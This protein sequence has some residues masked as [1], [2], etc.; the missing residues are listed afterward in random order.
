MIGVARAAPATKSFSVSGPIDA[1]IRGAWG[2]AF[3]GA[4]AIDRESAM[5]IAAVQRGRDQL[6]SI[7]TLPLV[8][9]RGLDVVPNGFLEQPDPDVPRVVMLAQT[10]EDLLCD[11]I[12]WWLKTSVDYRGFPLTARRVVNVTAQAPA[13]QGTPAPLPSGTDPRG[14][15]LWVDGV[16]VPAAALIRFDSP[17]RPLLTT[18]SR[19]VRRAILLDALAAMY[20]ENPRPLE[21]FTDTDN[22]TVIPYD[23]DQVEAF[24]ANY[25]MSRRRGGPAWVPKQVMRN[26]VSAPSPAELQLVELQRQASLELALFMGLDPE[27][28][29]VNTTSR[30]YFNAQ[31]R[32]TDKINHT[33]GPIMSAITDRLS[34]GDITPRGQ[35]VRFDLTEYLKPDPA[36]LVTY[37]RGLYDMNA[38]SSAEVRTAAGWSGSPPPAAAANTA[39]ALSASAN[40]R[41]AGNTNPVINGTIV[42]PAIT[43]P[44]RLAL[45]GQTFSAAPRGM[46]FSARDFGARGTAKTDVEKRTI[47][48]LAVPYG[49]RAEK[50]GIGFIFEPGSL[51]YDAD[52]VHRIRVKDEHNAYI[53]VHQAV[54][55]SDAGPVVTLKILD[56]PEGSPAKQQ[57]DGVLMDAAGGLYDGLSVGVDF[58]L[59]GTDVRWVEQTQTYHVARATWLETSVT[60]DPAFTGARVTKVAASNSGGLTMQCTYCG[61]THPA[62]MACATW[63]Q[64]N[65][66]QAPAP[67]AAALP[68]FAMAGTPAPA[69]AP[70]QAPATFAAQVLPAGN[71]VSAEQLTAALTGAVQNMVASGQI[72]GAPAGTPAPA[73]ADAGQFAQPV[74]PTAIPMPGQPGMPGFK[75]TVTEPTPYRLVFN[76]RTGEYDLRQGSHDFS[77]DLIGWL[78]DGD[79]AGGDRAHAFMREHFNVAT[80]DVDELNPTRQRPD[81]WTDQR[82]YETPVWNTV[83][84]GALTDITPFAFPKFNSASG[85]VAAHTEGTEPSTGTYTVTNQTI[86]PTA[87]SG[88]ARINR[89]VW[90]QGGNPQ[91]SGLIWNQMLRG[92]REAWEAL[93]ITTLNAGSFT[94]LATLTA[95]AVD[96]QAAGKTLGQ[97]LA[98][99][100]SLLQFARGGMRFRTAFAQADLYQC[101]V[102]A[103]DTAGAPLYPIVG[104]QNRN[105]STSNLFGVVDLGGMPFVPAWA[106]AAAGQT[107]A[108]K[109]YLIDPT[110]V[111]AWA[112]APQKL[113]LDAI[114]V[115]YVDLGIWGYQACA[116]SDTAGVRTITWDPVA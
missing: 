49:A 3:L 61:H 33:F 31:D 37:W 90:D 95:G 27:D 7:G 108:T 4:G 73:A 28:V 51:E 30:T 58:D 100:L 15:T 96:R 75:A 93:V 56:A 52:N 70:Q 43:A 11:G 116:V 1:L 10:I 103:A 69:A 81:M 114:A 2:T 12:S 76:R 79:K 5:S 101:L 106:L 64:L 82:D 41:I 25:M 66:Q 62:G 54:A 42:A 102:A 113:T 63:A 78:K 110:S 44:A 38:I 47:T 109:S 26:D 111:S 48:G 13:K 59:S 84:K 39:P 80:T 65:S 46:Q 67:N 22:A 16:Q 86:T 71:Q 21:T 35:R 57:R 9:Y 104:P 6:C 34:M 68:Q 88:K 20:A 72:S 19:V 85:L 18:G 115:A 29:G 32:R 50:Y 87:Y 23:D 45:A 83:Y 14:A 36:T 97:E 40:Y 89:E 24:L 98:S 112:S 60:P 17:G 107:A 105:G 94:A 8:N 77:R 91:V 99:G 92:A 74:S 55:D 53:G